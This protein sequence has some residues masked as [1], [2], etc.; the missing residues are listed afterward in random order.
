[1][2][3]LQD[4]VRGQEVIVM[5]VNGLFSERRGKEEKMVL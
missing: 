5:V 3:G 4:G 1:M 2:K